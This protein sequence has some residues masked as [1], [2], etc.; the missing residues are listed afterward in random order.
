MEDNSDIQKNEVTDSLKTA[1]T[2]TKLLSCKRCRSR[3]IRCNFE[4]P[5]CNCVKSGLK[6]IKVENDLRKRR[7]PANYVRDLESKLN[8]MIDFFEQFK[9]TESIPA[10]QELVE[11]TTLAE[12]LSNRSE[13]YTQCTLDSGFESGSVRLVY[14]P[15][16]VFDEVLVSRQ[17][18]V[19]PKIEESSI[20]AM[21]RDPDILH[22]LKLFFTWQYPSHNFYIFREAFLT[23][24]FDPKPNSLYCSKV[25]I[26]SICALGS[27]MSEIDQIYSRSMEFYNKARTYLLDNLNHPS[28]TSL[29]SFLLL[30][31]YDICNGSNSSGWMLSGNA[32]RMGF[33]IGFQLHP[34]AWFLKHETLSALDIS[35]RS[36]IYWGCYMADHFISM[37]LGRPSILKMSDATIPET[38]ELPDLEWIDEFMYVDPKDKDKPI[39]DISISDPLKNVIKL[40]NISDNILNDVFTR[41][42]KDQDEDDLNLTSRLKKLEEYNTQIIRWKN[43]LASEFMWDRSSF[44]RTGGNPNLLCIQ[45]YYYILVLC[46]NRPF[47]GILKAEFKN[48]TLSPSSLCSISIDDLLVMIKKFKENNGLRRASIFIVYCSILSISIIL[49]TNTSEQL[50][51]E[52]K[53]KLNFFMD[54]LKKCSKTWRLAEKSYNF[55]RAKLQSKLN[56]RNKATGHSRLRMN[57]SS[58]PKPVSQTKAE[59]AEK[60]D[61]LIS[62]DYSIKENQK[63]FMK[64]DQFNKEASCAL[65]SS[66]S[67][68]SFPTSIENISADQFA[69][70]ME[71]S[72]NSQSLENHPDFLGGP[73]V[74]MTSD[75]FNENWESLF[76]DY[77]FS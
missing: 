8:S 32:M 46:L 61:I 36:R 48:E 27:R 7:P 67:K 66:T 68:N 18:T 2:K 72:K 40:I 4:Y 51:I 59:I 25:L 30:A 57:H 35:I 39:T 64:M 75:L 24:F 50:V 73:P 34:E 11:K 45:Y 33:D 54:V 70:Y 5:C 17:Q 20:L 60:K 43:S 23:D 42:T 44:E 1:S 21:N 22:C 65:N 52:E 53:D 16:S 56:D 12:I 49:L 31:F 14:G 55:I 19:K 58:Q 76:P 29:Q 38:E 26:W 9:R 3:K 77:I 15:I 69:D 37:L 28:I 13:D 62:D 47:L 41:T 71:F 6:C 10:K 63:E 74:L